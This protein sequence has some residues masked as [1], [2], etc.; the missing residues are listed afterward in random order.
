M[1]WRTSKPKTEVQP[2]KG[3]LEESQ[4]PFGAGTATTTRR[5]HRTT[6]L[7]LMTQHEER[8]RAFRAAREH[9][10][11]KTEE[12]DAPQPVHDFAKRLW[13]QFI[14]YAQ[15]F[16]VFFALYWLYHNQAVVM[17]WWNSLI[18]LVQNNLL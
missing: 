2:S 13:G 5:R 7:R 15:L 17:G 11:S 16:I 12:L 10:I 8:D 9:Y 4:A 1:F 18:S 3:E 14:T 6:E